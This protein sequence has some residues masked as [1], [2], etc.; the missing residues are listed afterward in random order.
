VVAR[1]AGSLAQEGA[2]ACERRGERRQR[3]TRDLQH[4]GDG[5][6]PIAHGWVAREPY[7]VRRQGFPVRR[8]DLRNV[9]S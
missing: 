5:T 8:L 4:G 2:V 1:R 6:V 3:T 7:A 9:E